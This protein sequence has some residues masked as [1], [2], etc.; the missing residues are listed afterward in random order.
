MRIHE[1]NYLMLDSNYVVGLTDGEGSFTFRLNVNP[2]RRNRMEPRFYIKLQAKDKSLIDEV[3]KFFGCGKVYIQRD[4]RPRHSDCYRFE[5]G[6]RYDL[7]SVI[8]P[9]FRRHPLYI[10]S[11]Q[12]DFEL[13]CRA[14]ELFRAGEHLTEEG[15]RQLETIKAEMH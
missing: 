9:F 5:I 8:I 11:K 13:F 14:M 7:L 6:N 10:P 2:S 3:Q 4:R 15:M 1:G 12:K